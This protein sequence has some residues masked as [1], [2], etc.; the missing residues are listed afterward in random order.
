[1]RAVNENGPGGTHVV[2]DIAG[3]TRY[4]LFCWLRPD[5]WGVLSVFGAPI[6]GGVVPRQRVVASSPDPDALA[7]GARAD[8]RDQA[9]PY[10]VVD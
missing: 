3:G 6:P 4:L 8:V 10:R 2:S 5:T 9:R 1:M 7:L